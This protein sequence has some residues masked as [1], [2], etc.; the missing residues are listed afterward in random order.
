MNFADRVGRGGPSRHRLSWR[1]IARR[2]GHRFRQSAAHRRYLRPR[3]Y[4]AWLGK[5]ACD[6]RLWTGLDGDAYASAAFL[7]KNPPRA[8][9]RAR[10]CSS[11][12]SRSPPTARSRSACSSE[13]P[14]AVAP[15]RPDVAVLTAR[16]HQSVTDDIIPPLPRQ[17]REHYV[18]PPTSPSC[19]P[20]WCRCAVCRATKARTAIPRHGGCRTEPLGR[21]RFPPPTPR[22]PRPRR[23]SRDGGGPPVPGGATELRGVL[24]PGSAGTRLTERIEIIAPRPAGAH[25]PAGRGGA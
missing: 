21:S 8:P 12:A 25:R 6:W 1:A 18:D 23:R 17:V 7:H 16:D 9:T 2:C 24:R 14:R 13:P 5:I 20:S 3:D 4:N 10:R 15:C 19:I 22:G 11:S